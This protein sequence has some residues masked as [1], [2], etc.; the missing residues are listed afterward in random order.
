MNLVTAFDEI[1]NRFQC[2]S[3]LAFDR[4]FLEKK[5]IPGDRALILVKEGMTRAWIARIDSGNVQ[6]LADYASLAR[7]YRE[8]VKEGWTPFFVQFHGLTA[9]FDQATV[10]ELG[11]AEALGLIDGHL[12]TLPTV[13]KVERDRT[14]LDI[15]CPE[16]YEAVLKEA[17]D[18]GL[19]DKFNAIVD[20]MC[21]NF[22]SHRCWYRCRLTKDYAPMSFG[23]IPQTRDE[24]HGE[25]RNMFVGGLIFHESL[26]DWGTHT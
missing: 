3:D 14:C 7:D 10:R 8:E 11:Q 15:L 23:W 24:E 26:Q 19:L 20:R 5:A 12:A 16:H 6:D 25:W 22:A 1:G 9:D 21:V 2:T 13:P 17:A 18:R 4:A